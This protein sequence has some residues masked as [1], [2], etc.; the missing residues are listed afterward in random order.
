MI[1]IRVFVKK[2]RCLDCEEKH[3]TA[4]ATFGK[5]PGANIY[6]PKSLVCPR[7][8]GK[9]TLPE[10]DVQVYGPG[11]PPPAPHS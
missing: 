4:D 9:N 10:V 1:E 5:A 6:D 3:G 7:C 8:G 2:L 11:D